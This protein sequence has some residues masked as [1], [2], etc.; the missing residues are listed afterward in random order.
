MYCVF[1]QRLRDSQVLW[2][3]SLECFFV[4]LPKPCVLI[5]K[6]IVVET[7]KWRGNVVPSAQECVP[8]P[9]SQCSNSAWA[10]TKKCHSEIPG[11]T[12]CEP[13]I[14]PLSLVCLLAYSRLSDKQTRGCGRGPSVR[15]ESHE[16]R[17]LIVICR[18]GQFMVITCNHSY[19]CQRCSVM[20]HLMTKNSTLEPSN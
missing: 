19:F 14:I 1:M 11:D 20:T 9:R 7:M 16:S 13:F 12:L 3:F 5:Q 18:V 2:E 4:K 6:H 8:L 17:P 15:F 10:P